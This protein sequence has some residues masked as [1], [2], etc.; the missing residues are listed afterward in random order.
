MM[1]EK[2]RLKEMLAVLRDSNIINGITPEKLYTILSRLGPTFIKL[3]QIMSNRY[4]ILPKEYCDH[5]SKLRA[6]TNPMDF[7]E[8]TEILKE[9]Y[10]DPQEYFSEIDPQVLGSASMAQV[11]RATLKT[12]EKVVIKIQRKN[13]Y[14]TMSMD[15]K[16]LKKA[17]HI[18][19]LNQFIQI[20]DLN[21][22]LDEM[23][24][25]AKEE[26]NFEIEARNLEEFKENNKDIAYID[27]PIVYPNLVTKR[28]LVMEYIEGIRFDDIKKLQ[29]SGYDLE[30]IGLKLANNYI[31]QAIDD[32]LFHADLHPDNIIVRDG[33]IILIDLG[34]MGRISTRT[35]TLLKKCM[36]AI[37]KNDMYEIERNLINMCT[38]HAEIDHT[39]LRMDIEKILNKN[40]TTNIQEIKIME[41]ANSMF[42]ML[43]RYNLKLD[44][45]ITMLIRGITVIEGTLE[46]VSPNL[47]LM[48]VLSNKV[49]EMSINEIFS[50]EQFLQVGR[51]MVNG[52]S[53]LS[54]IPNE[55]LSLVTSLN[56]GETKFGIE[57]T[58]S[59]KQI[60]KLEAMLHQ[61]IIGLLDS[62]LLLG[63]SMVD[64]VLLQNLYLGLAFVLSVW[65]FIKMYIDHI[66]KGL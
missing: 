9:E 61:I 41:F 36:Q 30:E 20:I 5:L 60:D 45:D 25:V 29:K 31:K 27:V 10:G 40:A 35:R 62:A 52:S 21:E 12:G 28:T 56:R 32:G 53:S 42:A 49:K 43:R 7:A 58:N 22:V 47:N 17:I 66:H 44:K 54:K 23:F 4:D 24:Y 8:V 37:L 11:H 26:M 63:A 39:K 34:M 38:C 3:G 18:L 64:N 65:L 33:K 55:L 13:I 46:I 51:N 15:M 6:N 1:N 16:L 59:D 57:M 50:K 48:I 14:E 2:E 19:H